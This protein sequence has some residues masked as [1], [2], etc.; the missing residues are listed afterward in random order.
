MR[1]MTG[2]WINSPVHLTGAIAPS[3]DLALQD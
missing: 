2:F 3:F 1:G